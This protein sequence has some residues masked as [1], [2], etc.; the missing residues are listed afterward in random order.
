MKNYFNC[1]VRHFEKVCFQE[2][3][4]ILIH[5]RQGW[6]VTTRFGV[7]RKNGRKRCKA[8]MKDVKMN[9][10]KSN[11]YRQRTKTTFRQKTKSS[12]EAKVKNRQ[13]YTFV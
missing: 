4:L 6:T 5:F 13:F 1:S 3:F 8:Y 7:T 12:E 2:Y 9:I 11:T 10:C